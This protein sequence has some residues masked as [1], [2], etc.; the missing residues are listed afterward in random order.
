MK[1]ERT[2]LVRLKRLETLRGI[3]RQT[4]LAEAGK[5][6]AR[7]AELEHLGSRTAA[8]ITGYAMRSDAQS[9]GDLARQRIYLGELERM[10]A[11]NA[12]DIARA[13]EQADARAAQAAAAERSRAAAETRANAT[14]ARI[15][16]QESAASVPLGARPPRPT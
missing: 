10:V 13:R 12:A 14:E 16:R 4:A 8:L 1:A 7:L 2:R 9:G 6:E 3:A 5:A 11:R 15:A